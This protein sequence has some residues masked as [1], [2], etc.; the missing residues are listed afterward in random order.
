[1]RFV[2]IFAFLALVAVAPVETEPKLWYD[3]P[4]SQWIEALPVGNG[5]LGAMVFGRVEKERIQLNEESVWAGSP[6]D[7]DRKGA[8][9]H[10]PRIREL[11]FAGK[12]VE[13]EQ[14]V[15]KE[16][17]GER[18]YP[19]GYQTLGDLWIE[20]DPPQS[21]GDYRRE[22]DLST[23]I[24]KTEYRVR[25]A[26]FTREV[27][28]SAPHENLMALLRKSTLYNLFDTH[29]PF[30]IDGNFGGTAAVAE[31]LL[32]SH[33]GE[34]HLLPALPADWAAGSVEGLRA[35]GGFEVSVEWRDGKPRSAQIKSL[36]GNPLR[37]RA[38]GVRAVLAGAEEVPVI[39]SKDGSVEFPTVKDGA[40]SLSF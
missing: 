18:I 40:Y 2:K 35:R 17:M 11:L 34:V 16:I 24:V 22:L 5:S 38:A 6:I 3:E 29:P 30:Q 14:L 32:Q 23:G 7:R 33:A 8:Y 28:A 19:R 4:D 25:N 21:L 26:V 9:E 37:L 15:E 1:M 20:T 27:F 10:L 12:Y 36:L 39:K 13:A 31:M